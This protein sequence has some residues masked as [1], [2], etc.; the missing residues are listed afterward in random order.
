MTVR[1]ALTFHTIYLA[2]GLYKTFVL[3][4]LWNWFAVPAFNVPRVGYWTM[5]G[6]NLLVG[7]LLDRA[8]RDEETEQRWKVATMV[9]DACVPSENR[10]KLNE[11]LKEETGFGM[12]WT[13]GTSIFEKLVYNTITLGLGWIISTVLV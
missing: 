11:Q 10:E 13:L 8:Y 6:V 2:V 5:Y 1:K 12:L 3:Q 9:L 4:S 7:M